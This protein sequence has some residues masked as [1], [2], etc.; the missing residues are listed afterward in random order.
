MSV[1]D[2]ENDTM[3]SAWDLVAPSIAQ[4]DAITSSKGCST[5]QLSTYEK[6]NDA[7][8]IITGD[9]SCSKDVLS[10]LYEKAAEKQFMNFQEYCKRYGSKINGYRIFLI[11]CGGSGKSHCVNLIQRDMSYML[12]T[13]LNADLD[14]PFVLV[15]APIGSAAFQIC[16]TTIHSAFL[17]YEGSTRKPSWE[18]HTIMQLKL[19]HIMLSITDEISMVGFT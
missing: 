3:Q 19:E 4:E 13:V 17:L 6:E 5:L 18:K 10:K 16:G 7:H 9:S 2:I 1:H 8:G 12:S 11:G 14:Q 15:T